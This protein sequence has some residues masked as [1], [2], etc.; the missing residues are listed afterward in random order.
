MQRVAYLVD[1]KCGVISDN[2][3]QRRQKAPRVSTAFQCSGLLPHVAAAVGRDKGPDQNGDPCNRHND[4]L[5]HEE[6]SQLVGVH[7]Q[8]GQAAEPEEKET[9]HGGRVDA[10]ALWNVVLHGQERGPDGANHDTDGIC[11]IHVLDGEPEDGENGA[12]DDGDVRTP[13]APRGAGNDGERDMVQNANGT[14]KGNDKGYD[15]EGEGNNAER[16]APG[17]AYSSGQ[18]GAGASGGRGAYRWQ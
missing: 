10:L 2:G 18:T 8:K 3:R 17:Q 12:R 4:T 6:P 9:D 7:D 13:E 11:A 5:G 16:F 15:E 14:V 1:R